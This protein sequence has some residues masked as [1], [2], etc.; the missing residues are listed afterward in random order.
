MPIELVNL[1]EAV[2]KV[3]LLVYAVVLKS[4]ML[5]HEKLIYFYNCVF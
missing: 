3:S 4:C 1:V 2:V 5:T